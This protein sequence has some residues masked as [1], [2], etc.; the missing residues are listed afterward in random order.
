MRLYRRTGDTMEAYE[1][2]RGRT[3]QRVRQGVPWTEHGA[4]C[5]MEERA[6]GP[7][8]LRSSVRQPLDLPPPTNIEEVLAS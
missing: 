7:V 5:S 3:Y 1:Q 8:Y 2:S 6:D 4:I